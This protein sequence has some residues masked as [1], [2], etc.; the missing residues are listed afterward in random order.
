MATELERRWHEAGRVWFLINFACRLGVL[1]FFQGGL[2]V[3]GV[4][5]R[6]AAVHKKEDYPLG[7]WREVR[8][9]GSDGVRLFVAEQTC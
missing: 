7:L 8:S 6:W 9:L 4:D 3:E 5:M 1:V 2:G